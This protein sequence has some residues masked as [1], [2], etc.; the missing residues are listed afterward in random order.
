MLCSSYK[1][2]KFIIGFGP[3][4]DIC[5]TFVYIIYIVYPISFLEVV[6]SSERDIPWSDDGIYIDGNWSML[7]LGYDF[8]IHFSAWCAIPSD[9]KARSGL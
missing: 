9:T 6:P 2:H 3:W 8:I 5:N 1:I 4:S 7:S